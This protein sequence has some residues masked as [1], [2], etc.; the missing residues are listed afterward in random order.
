MQ[1]NWQNVAAR[2]VRGLGV[3]SGEL[4]QVRDD[5]GRFDVLLE[6]L[7]AI[8]KA[9]AVPLP[10]LTPAY[11]MERLWQA[12][13]PE[14]LARW[15]QHRD[16]WLQQADRV[17]VLAGAQPDF[18]HIP[19]DAFQAWQDAEQRLT[20]IEEARQLPYLL[21]AVPTQRRAAQLGMTPEELEA[22]LLPALGVSVDA[23][24][25]E[26]QRVLLAARGAQSLTIRSGDAN[27]HL[28]PGNRR[29]LSDDGYIDAADRE[30]GAIVSNLPA[31]SIYTTV[32]ETE[33]TGTLWLPQAGAARDVTMW[34][35][36]GR[37]AE[38]QAASGGEQ[39]TAMFDRHS[40]E[41]RRVGHIGI[42][43]NPRLR[44]PIGWTLVDEH[45]HGHL[46]IS[47]GENRYMGGKNVSSLNV[48]FAIP[49]ATLL[50]DGKPLI[51]DGRLR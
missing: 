47:F 41:P 43:L 51:A 23:L 13:R 19:A 7:L 49:D 32:V 5:S 20:E 21:V 24:Q 18:S 3:Q 35:E 22:L 8:E 11:Y 9:G 44:Q 39:L 36:N 6:I 40:G 2:I 16:R 17:V 15:D 31:G 27:L 10:Q 4:I 50:L 33:T 46:F 14:V 26:I 34:F 45:V 30:A 12:A 25:G 28:T 29:W 1:A 48:D 42:G 38:I 37:I